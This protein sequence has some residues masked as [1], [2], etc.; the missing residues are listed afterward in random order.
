MHLKRRA[1]PCCFC[2]LTLPQQMRTAQLG[3][4]ACMHA[5]SLHTGL[6]PNERPFSLFS[7]PR[8]IFAASVP[9][10]LARC[11]HRGVDRPGCPRPSNSVP[12]SSLVATDR[13]GFCVS[14][15]LDLCCRRSQH[16]A[17]AIGRSV[18]SLS[19]VELK[20]IQYQF[21]RKGP[22]CLLWTLVAPF[23]HPIAV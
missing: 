12:Y 21:Q 17:D 13:I 20:P 18:S 3:F 23:S 2:F 11:P 15:T 22:S 16:S 6:R 1:W 9:W 19:P 5:R 14:S 4:W 7:A 8:L 10:L